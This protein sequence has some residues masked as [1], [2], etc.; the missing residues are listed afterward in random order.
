[1]LVAWRVPEDLAAAARTVVEDLGAPL[2]LLALAGA[3]VAARRRAA[4]PVLAVTAADLAY[5][6]LVNPMGTVDRQTL[7]V[8]EAGAAVLAALAL[9]ALAER[10]ASRARRELPALAAAAAVAATLARRDARWAGAS[11]GWAAGELLGG[12]GALGAVPARAVVVCTS[13]DA[14][15]GAMF[16]QWVEGE[17]PDVS[18]LPEGA[19]DDAPSWRRL[20][21]RRSLLRSGEG[22]DAAPQRL[23]WLVAR[24]GARL[25]WE[26]DGRD[27]PWLPLAPAETPVLARVGAGG[28]VDQGAAD[29]AALAWVLPRVGGEGVGARRLGAMVLFADG[30]RRARGDAARG[31]ALWRA[32][33]ALWPEH[34]ASWTNLG[35]LAARAGDLAAAAAMTRRG[36]DLQP[37]RPRAW[38]NLADYLAAAGDEAGAAEARREA[39]RR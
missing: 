15:G 26:G 11:D 8:A 4:W 23:R 38:R 27:M 18:V 12:A 1:M 9:G 34:A 10:F 3:L 36:L 24:A 29:R 6:A 25:R 16:A 21:L 2:S 32:A 22:G 14:C 31:E 39:A 28:G 5:T 37:D 7:F 20:E 19:L 13:D 35:V 30:A 33:L 17:R